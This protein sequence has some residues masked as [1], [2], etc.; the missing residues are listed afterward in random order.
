M[1]ESG[2][3]LIDEGLAVSPSANKVPV[4]I[5]CFRERGISTY[6]IPSNSIRTVRLVAKDNSF[7]CLERLYLPP[8]SLRNEE[9]QEGGT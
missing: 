5:D 6:R 9:R 4:S 2:P 7:R 8:M 3:E 1:D